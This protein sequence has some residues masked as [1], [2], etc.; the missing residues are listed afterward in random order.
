M[1]I[2]RSGL[3]GLGADPGA[4]CCALAPGYLLAAPSAQCGFGTRETGREPL[5]HGVCFAALQDR[6]RRRCF[7]AVCFAAPSRP[8]A[9]ALLHDRLLRRPF[10][11]VCFATPSGPSASALLHGRLL[12]RPFRTVCV[13]AASRPSA[14]PPFRTV[15]V[16]AASRPS[17]SPPL[18]D[19]LRRRC[20]TAVCFAA[21]SGPSASALLHDRFVN[22]LLRR[23]SR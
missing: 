2:A 13:G 16:G 7:T 5:L 12:R 1:S 19:R 4:A 11:T 22:S 18:Q 9:S 23:R 17:A 3:A 6:L 10:R 20:F 8:S 21:P 14:S 15:C